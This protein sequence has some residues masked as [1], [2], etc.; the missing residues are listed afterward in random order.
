MRRMQRDNTED[1]QILGPFR[2]LKLRLRRF[3]FILRAM[4]NY[5]RLEASI[6]YNH[7]FI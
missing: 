5:L 1:K 7:I 2:V 3:A 4:R 6:W